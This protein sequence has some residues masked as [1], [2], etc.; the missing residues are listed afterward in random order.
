MPIADGYRS[1]TD[2]CRG[3]TPFAD[4]HRLR[5][6]A[7]CGATPIEDDWNENPAARRGASTPKAPM[8]T[9]LHTRGG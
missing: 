2:T 9:R 6:D 1:L 8:Q 4:R 3:R 7:D 5:T